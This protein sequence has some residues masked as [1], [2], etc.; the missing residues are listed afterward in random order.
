MFSARADNALSIFDLRE[1]A[2]NFRNP[3]DAEKLKAEQE[4]FIQDFLKNNPNYLFLKQVEFEGRERES[5]YRNLESFDDFIRKDIL[6]RGNFDTP[7]KRLNES[8]D[9]KF[10][11]LLGNPFL[12]AEERAINQQK[13]LAA[14]AGVNPLDL[15]DENRERAALV[16]EA[17]ATRRAEFDRKDFELRSKQ[18]TATTNL[19][20]VLSDLN[21]RAKNGENVTGK[22]IVEIVDRSGAANVLGASPVPEDMTRNYDLGFFGGSNR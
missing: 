6:S 22:Q 14:T 17:E 10:N 21:Q 16:R 4:R 8:L 12:S 15:S 20:K 1:D 5:G 7:Q 3:F 19:T 11:L 9:Q 18:L 2:A 13:F